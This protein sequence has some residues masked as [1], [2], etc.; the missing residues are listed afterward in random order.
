VEFKI[1]KA[2]ELNIKEALEFFVKVFLIFE[3]IWEYKNKSDRTIVG[4]RTF[5]KTYTKIATL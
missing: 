5:L 1:V 2:R 4:D 3:S